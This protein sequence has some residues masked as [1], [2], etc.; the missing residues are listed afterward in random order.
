MIKNLAYKFSLLL[1]L[2]VV[3][4][5]MVFA[6]NGN[7]QLFDNLKVKDG[8]PS[9]EV[10]GI[11]QDSLG[12]MWFATNDG[13]VRFDGYEMNVYRH[14]RNRKLALPNNQVTAIVNGANLCLWVS[15]YEGLIYFESK[16]GNSELID[17]GGIREIR[18]LLNQGDSVLWAGSSEGLFRINTADRSFKLYNHQNSVLGADIVRSLYLDSGN[19]LW[20]GTFD[21]LNILTAQGQMYHFDL[22][23]NYKPEL[24]NNLILDIQ[25]YAKH[26]DSL[27]LVGTETGLV[28]FNRY[29]KSSTVFNASNTKMEN[30]VV[31]CIYTN[32]PGQIYFGSDF[33]FYFFNINTH[34]IQASFHDP[35]NNYSIGNNV[36]WDIYEDNAG[37]LWMATSNGISK[38]NFSQSMFGFTPVY[39]KDK[40]EIT[41]TQVNDLYIDMEQYIWLATKKGVIVQFKNGTQKT[42]TASGPINQRLVLNN[43]NTISGDKLGRIWIGSAGGINIWDQAKSQMYTITANFDLNKGLRSNYIGA[44]ITPPDGSFWVTT[45]GGGMYKAKG[46]FSDL[47]NIYFEYV[48]N[49]NT[50]I[51]SANKK[52]W[53]KHENKI[54][55]IS[56]ATNNIETIP[57]L[58]KHLSLESI[59][60]VLVSSKGL[61]WIGA[62]NLLICFN[63]QTGEINDYPLFTGNNSYILNLLEDF[64]G[65]IWG[66]TLTSIF[67]F[68][69]QTNTIETYPKNNGI[70]LDNFL[71][72]SKAISTNGK[73]FF[74]GNDGFISFF[75]NEI[76]KNNF[77]PNIL[78]TYLKVNNKPINSLNELG[79]RNNNSNQ[80]SYQNNLSLKYDQH[81][82]TIGF[83][84]L[85]YGDPER[86]IYAYKLEGYDTDWNYTSNSR[87]YASYSYLSPGKYEFKVRGTNNEG[88]WF[89]NLCTLNIRVKPPI[90]ASPL[91]IVIYILFL[92]FALVSLI[93]TYRNKVK[94]KEKIRLITMEKEKNEEIAREKQLFFTNISHEFRTPLSLI[95]GPVEAILKKGQLKTHD[96]EML[97]LVAK[98]ARRL[99][100]LVNQLLDLRKIETNTLKLKPEEADVIELCK[101]QFSHFADLAENNQIDYQF[102]S[103]SN[104][105]NCDIDI[106][107][108]E[109]IIQNLLSNAFKFTPEKG[110]VLFWAE[111]LN[112]KVLKI[113][114]SD[115]GKGIEPTISGNI[116][117]R[118]YQGTNLSSNTTGY[119][120]GLNIAKEYCELMGGKI[121][122]DS[123]VGKGSI[124]YVEIPI[125]H[126]SPSVPTNNEN[127]HEL[128]VLKEK[129]NL[130]DS[131]I[132]QLVNAPCILLVDDHPDT[133]K[134]LQ[135]SLKEEYRIL[136]AHCASEALN[137]LNRQNVDLIVSDIMMPELDG[138]E[139]CTIVKQHPK[140]QNIPLVLLTAK[141]LDKQKI[142]G[143]N[144]GSDAYVTKPFDME[145]LKAQ[146]TGLLNRNQKIDEYIKR[147]L[148][149]ENQQVKIESADEKLLQETIKYINEHISDP[150]INLE[151]M[152]KKIGVS[153][154]SLYRKIKG[155]TGMTLNELIRNIKL[156]K[157]AQLIKTGKLS[158]SE[159]MYETGF[160]NHS[161][162]AKCF[163]KIYKVAPKEYR[164]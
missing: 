87:N 33:G 2:L 39:S 111:T 66:T 142:E 20:V 67:R 144:A 16:T 85:H 30:E 12:F 7:T 136:I 153:H 138:I 108:F 119:G 73:L 131:E 10:F 64:N 152:C 79:G 5:I 21:G 126:K 18:C 55:S 86:N 140:Y 35:F 132:N 97:N 47:Q 128:T 83:S 51:F 94:W 91:A 26:N 13:F 89:N 156:K 58:N 121:W 45:W 115:T 163:K 124:F 113:T 25:P 109:S 139:F 6:Q 32:S 29:L 92:Q 99:L 130:F 22:K 137:I 68:S 15:S 154:S 77:K 107:K 9:N 41:G 110:S 52:I 65:D 145:V 74:G 62:H 147:K 90:W 57:A 59:S 159:I 8:L 96:N 48:A 50:N 133:L 155:Q 93:I 160:S 118:F 71:G 148:I 53:L 162:F 116:F 44:F 72:E 56:L 101:K 123:E 117:Q 129:P 63:I 3:K 88:V 143:F 69:T 37:I 1:L 120:I 151:T 60:S 80:I 105:F 46:D 122:F 42:F 82:F 158:I 104:A 28:I 78:L 76:G 161:Y 49:F 95:L 125:S 106:P 43:I 70:P 149:V 103:S 11:T 14:D 150:E 19:N 31:K 54:Y 114:I 98:N 24:K 112:N 38:L 102:T 141:T 75:P 61:L 27:L 34:E 164:G 134:Y 135:L 17:L 36:V 23:G 84:A 100:S 127:S 157:A 81:S 40:N 4:G 146:I